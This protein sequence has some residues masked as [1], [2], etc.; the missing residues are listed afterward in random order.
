MSS[1]TA[2]HLTSAAEQIFSHGATPKSDEKIAETPENTPLSAFEVA[3]GVALT[4]KSDHTCHG[5]EKMHVTKFLSDLDDLTKMQLRRKYAAEANSHRN[6]LTRSKRKGHTVHPA[7]YEF[8]DFLRLVGPMPVSGATLA[9]IDNTDPEYAPGKVRWADKRTQNNN[10]SDT[11]TIYDRRTGEV[12]TASRLAKLQGLSRSAIGKRRERGWSDAEIIAGFRPSVPPDIN[13]EPA[14]P[15]LVV[16]PPEKTITRLPIKSRSA[17][18]IQ[19]ER[20]ARTIAMEREETGEEPLPAPHYVI[21]EGLPEA[22][23]VTEERWL[24]HFTR[25]WPEFRPHIIFERAGSYHQ[26]AIELIDP[27]YA[28]RERE[29]I[30]LREKLKSQL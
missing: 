11:L 1:N 22:W 26:R 23:H 18:Q 29:K 7:L 21:N 16:T 10:K 15:T 28:M 24:A 9:R 17:R 25:R 20:M 12:F 3:G 14:P 2:A 4:S 13:N 8:R 5:I 6:M 27:A 19:F 30:A